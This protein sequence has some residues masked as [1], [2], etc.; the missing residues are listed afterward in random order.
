ML[1][2]TEPTDHCSVFNSRML[3]KEKLR[4]GR[5][6]ISLSE[7]C[8]QTLGPEFNSQYP[9]KNM[10]G[11]VV[12]TGNSRAHDAETRRSLGLRGQSV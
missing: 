12:D 3:K 8:L 2:I 9:H 4:V 6:G 1:Y 5:A 10:S 7:K 11:M